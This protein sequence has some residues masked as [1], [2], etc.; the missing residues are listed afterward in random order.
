MA[1]EWYCKQWKLAGDVEMK[2]PN[3]TVYKNR[4]AI[5]RYHH[6]R[7]RVADDGICMNMQVLFVFIFNTEL[8]T[9]R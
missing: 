6:A 8:L 2:L 5:D 7:S 4:H 1:C 9:N 3:L